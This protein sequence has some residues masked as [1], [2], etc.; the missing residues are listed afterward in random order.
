MPNKKVMAQPARTPAGMASGQERPR[1]LS[2][3]GRRARLAPFTIVA[4]ATLVSAAVPPHPDRTLLAAAVALA[5][6]LAAAG[7]LVPWARLP[8]EAEA[9]PPI[10][11]FAVVAL[12]RQSAGGA[13]SE[14]TP[15]VLLPVIWLA[16]YGTRR[17][18]VWGL[19]ALGTVLIGPLLVGAAP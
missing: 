19:L 3:A 15:L 12:L 9:L 18:L 13:A 14:F 17:E 4:A 8:R 16:L 10:A 11:Y 6:L 7:V 5:A 1:P 2:S